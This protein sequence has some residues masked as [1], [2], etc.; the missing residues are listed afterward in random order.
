MIILSIAAILAVGSLLWYFF[1]LDDEPRSDD[2][3]LSPGEFDRLTKAEPLDAFLQSAQERVEFR[4]VR[5]YY[6]LTTTNVG[7]G[8]KSW[9]I[10]YHSFWNGSP[11]YGY[12]SGDGYQGHYGDLT[13]QEA[14]D[15]ARRMTCEHLMGLLA[16]EEGTK[17]IGMVDD[18]RWFVQEHLN[19]TVSRQD[20]RPLPS[21]ADRDVHMEDQ[22]IYTMEDRRDDLPW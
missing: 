19:I 10:Y 14:K 17:Q 20:P 3:L 22:D 5:L 4:P 9:G 18:A 13:I 15:R 12:M 21:H 7:T 16:T 6:A 1:V 11:H 8:E 2:G